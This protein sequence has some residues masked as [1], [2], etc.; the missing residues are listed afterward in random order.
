M[1]H[2]PQRKKARTHQLN[3]APRESTTCQH[4]NHIRTPAHPHLIEGFEV[5]GQQLRPQFVLQ[6][7]LWVTANQSVPRVP[8]R[9]QEEEEEEEEE[10]DGN[11]WSLTTAAGLLACFREGIE[12]M[13]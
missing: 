4:H 9:T 6:V 2:H 1:D 5:L 3:P 13:D 8:Q 10:E 11:K 7:R 12:A